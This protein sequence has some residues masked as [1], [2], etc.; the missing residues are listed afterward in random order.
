MMLVEETPVLAD[1]LPVSRLGDQLRLG[2]GFADDGLQDSLLEAVLRAAI[3]AIEARTDKI[4]FQREFSLT[5]SR[6]ATVD[7]SDGLVLPIAP[8][9]DVLSV[10]VLSANGTVT[11]VAS[12]RYVFR[13]DL[14]RPWVV[15]VG[16][17]LPAIP[18][19]GHARIRFTAGYGEAW[20]AIP[21]DFQQAVMLLAAHYYEYRNDAEGAA[22]VMP[23]GVAA[24]IERH[25]WIRLAMGRRT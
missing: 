7:G 14:S 4:L 6:W 5:A 19:K 3:A 1:V 23:F 8:V 22:K 25:R 13:P 21:A 17:S 18:T 10:E 16:H 11:A 15:S 12:E 9:R 2:T 24:L 20:T